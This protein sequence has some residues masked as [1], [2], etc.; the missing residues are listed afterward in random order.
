MFAADLGANCGRDVDL[1]QIHANGGD[2]I[3][4]LSWA[5]PKLPWRPSEFAIFVGN[6]KRTSASMRT[7]KPLAVF[8]RPCAGLG[9]P[10]TQA[11]GPRGG[12]Y[13]PPASDRNS[14]C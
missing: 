4:T 3:P 10:H 11:L 2:G 9:G 7:V 14:S 6:D 12:R 13:V 8:A 5:L 1:P